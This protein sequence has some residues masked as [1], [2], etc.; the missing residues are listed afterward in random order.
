VSFNG[1][2]RIKEVVMD[3]ARL[4]PFGWGLAVGAVLLV[5][6]M[7]ATGWVVTSSTAKQKAQER[8]EKAVDKQM[9]EICVYQF[10]QADNRQKK[11]QK[12]AEMDYSW[13][14]AEYIRKQGWAS[15]PGE[16]ATSSGVADNCAKRI[17]KRYEKEQEQ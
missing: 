11:L 4:K 6:L 3:T 16:D 10:R 1:K 13:D 2:K 5:V 14:R 9:A 15:M 7:F 17:M 12:M 8:A